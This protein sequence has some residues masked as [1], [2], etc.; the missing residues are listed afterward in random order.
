MDDIGVEI[1]LRIA[2]LFH[3]LD[4]S[5]ERPFG[6]YARVT[7]N[8]DSGEILIQHETQDDPEFSI[9]VERTR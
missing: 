1:V 4:D 2:E 5:D 6:E 7:Y 8:C 3:D 9:Y